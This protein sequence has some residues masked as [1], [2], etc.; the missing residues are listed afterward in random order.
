VSRDFDIAPR[1]WRV[2]AASGD[3]P[4]NLIKGGEFLGQA[5][6]S[7]SVVIDLAQ[8]YDLRGF[9]L[10]PLSDLTL[11]SST[12]ALVGPPACFVAWV[13]MD[14]QTWGKPAGEGE[15][16]NIAA[17]RSLQAVLFDAPVSGRYLHLVLPRAIQDKPIIGLAGIGILTR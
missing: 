5:N 6:A 10:K 16:A 2:I 17:N 9:T 8:A 14:G 11:T 7:V 15:F 12:A 1:D 3:K 13:S 4:D